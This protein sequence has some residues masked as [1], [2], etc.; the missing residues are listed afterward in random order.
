MYCFRIGYKPNGKRSTCPKMSLWR[1]LLIR[2]F[3]WIWIWATLTGK[4]GSKVCGQWLVSRIIQ[5]ITISW[6]LWIYLH[7]LT[8]FLDQQSTGNNEKN[9]PLLYTRRISAENKK[10]HRTSDKLIANVQELRDS[11]YEISIVFFHWMRRG[12]RYV[13]KTMHFRWHKIN[14]P[15]GRLCDCK[16]I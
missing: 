9:Q 13:A 6:L 3:G 7:K 4:L 15:H 16:T 8:V 12:G 11:S 14:W 2:P 5:M 1:V 10:L